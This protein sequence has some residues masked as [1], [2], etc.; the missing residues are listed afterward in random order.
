MSIL[1]TLQESLDEARK[2]HTYI[3]DKDQYGVPEYWKTSLKGD[4]EDHALWLRQ[5]LKSKGI[6]SDLVYCL[7]ETGDGHLVLSVEGW[8]L[9]NRNK[10]VMRRDDLDYKWISIGKPDGDWFEITG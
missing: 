5:H 9:D 1:D 10:W 2:L 4:C 7:T 6:K 3:Y 8:I